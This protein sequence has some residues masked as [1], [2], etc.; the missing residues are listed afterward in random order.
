[1]SELEQIKMLG[2]GILVKK[3]VIL[4]KVE[5]GLVYTEQMQ[6]TLL[7]MHEGKVVAVGNGSAQPMEIEVGDTAHI[8]KGPQYAVIMLDGE[9]YWVL[10]Q[11]NV[12]F[13]KR[14]K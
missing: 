4:E 11:H 12:L 10:A 9:E 6:S 3:P 8:V 5:G 7:D 1:M 2:D 14:N 13:V